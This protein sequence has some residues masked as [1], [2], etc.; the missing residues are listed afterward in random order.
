MGT[1]KQLKTNKKNFAF[2]DETLFYLEEICK[3]ETRNMTNVIEF[4]LKE[5]ARFYKIKYTENL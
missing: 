2:S 3:K 5:K 1:K 4:A